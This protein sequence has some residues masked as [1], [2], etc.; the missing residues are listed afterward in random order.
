MFATIKSYRAQFQSDERG[1]SSMIFALSLMVMMLFL[2]TSVDIGRAF[3]AN[4]K[5]SA[6]ADAAVIAA[7]KGLKDA[8]TSV[9]DLEILAGKYFNENLKGSTS[10]FVTI[11]DFVSDVDTTKNEVKISFKADVPTIFARAA[12]FQTITISKSS[13]A[14]F[15][16][17]DIEVGLALD[18]TGSMSSSIG[19]K[20]KIAALKEAVGEFATTLMPATPVSGQSIR[21]GLAPYSAAVNLGA[22]AAA[23]SESRSSDGCVTERATSASYTDKSP[24]TGGRFSVALDGRNDVDATEGLQNNAYQCPGAVIKPLT[25]KRSDIIAAVNSYREGGWT[26]G[27]L[28]AQ[29]AWNLISEDWGSVWGGSSR[30]DSYSKIRDK[31]LFKAVILMTDGIFNTAYHNDT[32]AKQALALCQ[33][34]KD[35]GV[36]VFAVAFAAPADAKKTL[37]D[38]AT[39]GDAYFADASDPEDLKNAF[40]QFA[41]TIG[42]LRISQ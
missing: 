13:T 16:V 18:V 41:A 29:W 38:C 8:G 24:T 32:S 4:Q 1:V 7:A 3:H 2:G 35:R 12:G 25:D 11:R 14:V 23:A 31:K 28:G 34:M 17:R 9:A 39:T 36:V 30:P 6:A 27:H 19:G 26:A 40:K 22:F 20:T 21:V 33:N 37:Q 15:G 42:A 5:V 10:K